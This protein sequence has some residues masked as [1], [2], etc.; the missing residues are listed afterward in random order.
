MSQKNETCNH[1]HSRH[2]DH[3]KSGF[4]LEDAIVL[5]HVPPSKVV[6]EIVTEDFANNDADNRREVE[7][8]NAVEGVSV[9]AILP[10]SAK[11]DGCRDID[12]NGPGKEEQALDAIS[13]RIPE[14]RTL[15][16]TY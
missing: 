16:A 9:S 5:P 6:V 7:E 13:R 1:G 3:D 15:A 4:G 8:A 12:A 11:Q 14:Q 2:E 10:R